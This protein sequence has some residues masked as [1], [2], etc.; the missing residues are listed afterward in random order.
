MSIRTPQKPL[1]LSLL[2]FCTFTY[3]QPLSAQE[4]TAEGAA[5]LKTIFEQMLD[6]KQAE[7]SEN[8]TRPRELKL[9]GEV[10]VEPLDT[11]YAITLPSVSLQ[12]DNGTR[13]D[14]GIMALNAVPFEGDERYK[15]SFSVPSPIINYDATGGERSRFS[16]G[17]QKGAGIWNKNIF[18]FE[19]LDA[20][21]TDTL[22][23]ATTDNSSVIIPEM[24]AVY[25]LNNEGDRWTGPM[26]FEA[27]N[28]QIENPQESLKVNLGTLKMLMDVDQLTTEALASLNLASPE[29]LE[30]FKAADGIDLR[31]S[32]A[33]LQ[34]SKIGDDGASEEFALGNATFGFNVDGV[35]GDF[36]EIGFDFSFD[37]FQTNMMEGDGAELFPKSAS[38]GIAQKNIPVNEITELA[39]NLPKGDPQ[40]MMMPLMFS[41][42]A[43]LSEA[44]SYIEVKQTHARNH[45]YD[46]TLDT[47]VRAD[48][49][50]ASMATAEGT[51]RFAGLEKVLSLLQVAA[52][53]TDKE[54]A[55]LRSI[56]NFARNLEALKPYGRQEADPNFG[57]VHIFDLALDKTGAFTINGQ[58]AMGLVMGGGAPQPGMGQPEL[59]EPSS[60]EDLQ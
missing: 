57:F 51:L 60:G 14:I 25:D 39:Q 32:L 42:P 1:I 4:I 2:T 52:S 46:A 58:D 55:E 34:G 29:A 49:T 23:T 20:T 17:G 3:A 12:Y 6:Q 33:G 40:A 41:L 19:K 31:F 21:L 36:A 38:F 7:V 10:V 35:L 15:M 8:T 16:I 26:H 24:K 54:P 45:N 5:E 18:Q 9:E 22:V 53:D 43:I 48:S 28:I 11:Y 56:R 27:K 50:A 59:S 44:G 37:G 47:V 13:T 30:D